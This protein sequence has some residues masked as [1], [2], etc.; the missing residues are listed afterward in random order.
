MKRFAGREEIE[1]RRLMRLTSQRSFIVQETTE[2]NQSDGTG[3]RGFIFPFYIFSTSADCFC[4]ST[5]NI[6]NGTAAIILALSR[7]H[8]LLLPITED[9]LF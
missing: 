8:T 7:S 6:R 2:M 1:V 4:I 5:R 9:G 3:T